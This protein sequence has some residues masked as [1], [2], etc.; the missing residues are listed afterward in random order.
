VRELENTIEYAVAMTTQDVISEDLI[1]RGKGGEVEE[2]LKP[3]KDARDD[4]EK[5]YLVRLLELNQG[6]VSSAATMAGRYRADLY[7]LLKKHGINPGN[8]KK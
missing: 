6:N 2:V 8:F 5:W 1:L 3:F 4:F 7:I